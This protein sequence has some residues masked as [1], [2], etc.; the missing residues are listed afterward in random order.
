VNVL[1]RL[2][3][4]VVGGWIVACAAAH[5]QTAV[6]APAP[7]PASNQCETLSPSATVNGSVV[8]LS[9][10]YCGLYAPGSGYVYHALMDEN[11]RALPVWPSYALKQT[12]NEQISSVRQRVRYIATPTDCGQAP[13]LTIAPDNL[14][15]CAKLMVLNGAPAQSLPFWEAATRTPA[16]ASQ[17]GLWH[18]YA[19][20]LSTP[21]DGLA[22]VSSYKKTQT[23]L[24][25]ARAARVPGADALTARARLD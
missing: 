10:R 17:V 13:S 8:T 25:R 11:G 16:A 3:A 5:A 9:I 1:Q 24:Q 21:D 20:I 6:P 7:P 2:V 15:D 12:V 22:W 18:V 14:I 23:A 4:V 19:L